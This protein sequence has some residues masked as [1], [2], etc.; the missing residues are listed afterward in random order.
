[1][2]RTGLT[3]RRLDAALTALR[4]ARFGQ[5]AEQAAV[6]QLADELDN[7]AWEL[8]EQS[9]IGAVPDE[10]Y[11]AAFGRARAASSVGFAL[12]SNALSAALDAVYEAHAAT[13]DLAAVRAV[14]AI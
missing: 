3:D 5:T 11:R 4:N 9:E 10:A 2:E 6:Q 1:V 13:D 12:G 8:Q 7:I 14:V